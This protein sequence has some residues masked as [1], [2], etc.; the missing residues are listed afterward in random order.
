MLLPDVRIATETQIV[1][2][3]SRIIAAT[4]AEHDQL[5]WLYRA[6][7]RKISIIPPGVDVEHFQ[8]VPTAKARRM[9][10]LDEMCEVLLFVGRIEP[11]KAVD[12]ILEAVNFMRQ[13]ERDLLDCVCVVVIGG[14]PNNPNDRE[15]S[16]LQCLTKELNLE[17]VVKFFGAKDHKLLPLYYAAATTVIMPSDYE[18]FGMVALES[19]ASGTPVIASGVGGLAFLVDDQETGFLVPT[20][21]PVALAEGIIALLSD[22]EKR[23]LLGRNATALAQQ[24]TWVNIVDRLRELFEDVVF[25]PAINRHR[26]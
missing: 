15:L 1:N 6:D 24:Y 5:L 20:R 11:L 18:S 26:R 14:D 10:G 8:P 13:E 2:W 19:M 21:D 22:P 3:A 23:E 9:L 7:R 17:D 16:R 4:P 12:T 25:R